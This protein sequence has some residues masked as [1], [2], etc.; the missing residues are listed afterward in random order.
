MKWEIASGADSRANFY[1]Y[2]SISVFCSAICLFCFMGQT[3]KRVPTR[4]QNGIC[5]IARTTFGV[6]LLHAHPTLLGNFWTDIFHIEYSDP[7]YF[8]RIIGNSVVI[9]VVCMCID[10]FYNTVLYPINMRIKNNEFLHAVGGL[11]KDYE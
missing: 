2:N 8:M 4:V 9:F 3:L 5:Q 6:Y 1:A 7:F 10:I 11:W